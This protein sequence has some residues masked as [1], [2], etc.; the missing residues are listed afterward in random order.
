M[1]L[2]LFYVTGAIIVL[3]CL[4]VI[5]LRNPVTSAGLLVAALFLQGG[6]FAILGATFLA[7]VQVLIYAGAV[8]VLFLF[9]IMMIGVRGEDLERPRPGPVIIGGAVIVFLE[10]V[11]VIRGADLPPAGAPLHGSVEVIGMSLLEQWA[12]AFEILSVLLLAAI[13]GA[14][15]LGRRRS[16]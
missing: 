16:A 14:V 12:V 11:W 3:L 8:M 5:L 4:G 13:V 1:S 10:I 2:F 9:V 15:A 6:L 7:A